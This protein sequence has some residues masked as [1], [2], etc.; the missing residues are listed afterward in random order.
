MLRDIGKLRNTV[1]H[2]DWEGAH[3]DG[4][5]LYRMKIHRGKLCHEYIQFSV[6]SL[7]KI[8]EK[9]DICLEKYDEYEQLLES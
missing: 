8:L 9:I 5:T 3:D 2:A 6:E 1:V 4:Y 7:E